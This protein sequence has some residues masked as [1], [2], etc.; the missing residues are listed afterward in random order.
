MVLVD[1]PNFMSLHFEKVRD[2][3]AFF[4]FVDII[5]KTSL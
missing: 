2:G 5:I 1:F 3:R 4:R